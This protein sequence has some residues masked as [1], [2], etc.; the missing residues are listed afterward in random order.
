VTRS[1]RHQQRDPLDPDDSSS[2]W[3]DAG[4]RVWRE[5]SGPARV[6]GFALAL[7]AVSVAVVLV[8]GVPLDG[9][10]SGA[11]S[12]RPTPG[13]SLNAE[14]RAAATT[15][16]A[17]SSPAAVPVRVPPLCDQD[18]T[19]DMVDEPQ[20]DG[21]AGG[22]PARTPAGWYAS[23][24]FVGHSS[25][26]PFTFT[27]PDGWRV[28]RI[29]WGMQ[30]DLRT[31]GRTAVT[32]VSLPLASGRE[33]PDETPEA[34]L[35]RIARAAGLTMTPPVQTQANGSWWWT[36]D[37]GATPRARASEACGRG[38]SCVPVL[39]SGYDHI[40]VPRA[41][42]TPAGGASRLMLR[43]V[44]GAPLAVWLWDAPEPADSAADPAHIR[45]VVIQEALAVVDSVTVYP[46]RPW[47]PFGPTG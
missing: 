2:T 21:P 20:M 6:G 32:F 8:A 19:F 7:A 26:L 39:T 3:M 1:E 5:G 24:A 31:R 14:A 29:K 27:L 13:S 16:P 45:D 43:A 17:S 41:V 23:T 28:V 15:A 38:I 47:K 46:S 34:L 11:P 42:G 10:A 44:T 25:L 9:A 37:I 35:R 40:G 22:C 30:V 4:A 36:T 33:Q 12:A 18:T